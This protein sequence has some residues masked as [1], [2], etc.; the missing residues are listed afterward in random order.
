MSGEAEED[1]GNLR[2]GTFQLLLACPSGLTRE[3]V[4]VD[5]SPA[6]D[7]APH[8]DPSLELSIE[9][10]WNQRCK[11]QPHLYNGTKFRYAGSTVLKSVDGNGMHAPTRV[12][13]KLGLTD[14]RTFVGTNLSSRWEE[15]LSPGDAAEECRNLASNLGN[16]AVV[17]LADG[18]LLVLQRGFKVGEYPGAPVFPGGHSEPSE[19][20]IHGHVT[21]AG[22]GDVLQRLIVD[23][24]F[25]GILREVVEETGLPPSSLHDL[26]F[27]GISSRALNRR[28]TAFFSLRCLLSGHEALEAYKTAEHGFES[29]TLRLVSQ[30]K[31]PE[32]AQQMPG[33][34][35]G[36]AAL[37]AL[38]Q[39][40]RDH[41]GTPLA[42]V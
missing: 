42:N 6:Y 23:E 15:F 29:T 13:L 20:G 38:M 28:P 19:I 25:D 2:R 39:H 16:G 18:H 24:L 7:R 17:E 27:I 14:Y 32:L 26:R 10:T 36:G 12:C 4:T 31:L 34:H 21:E 41:T 5:F 30:G 8:P 40:F 33:C 11:E 3:Q 9:Q 22:Q 1:M 35:E 37:H